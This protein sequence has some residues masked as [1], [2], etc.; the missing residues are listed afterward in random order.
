METWAFICDY[1]ASAYYQPTEQGWVFLQAYCS[2]WSRLQLSATVRGWGY[3]ASC[4]SSL[5]SKCCECCRLWS[6]HLWLLHLKVSL[7]LGKKGSPKELSQ[8]NAASSSLPFLWHR[9]A[10]PHCQLFLLKDI[11][12]VTFFKAPF[13]PKIIRS[14]QGLSPWK[15]GDSYFDSQSVY[16]K[17]SFPAYKKVPILIHTVGWHL[18]PR[19]AKLVLT[20]GLDGLSGLFLP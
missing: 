6:Q 7:K 4:R 11:C 1:V 3:K 17:L 5:A 18:V 10:C 14:F 2:P 19:Y 12:R 15:E 8:I 16:T 20:V 9:S 13:K